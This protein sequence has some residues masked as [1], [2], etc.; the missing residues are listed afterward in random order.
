MPDLHAEAVT[1][2]RG[3]REVLRG[4]DLR[5]RAG[6]LTAILGPNGAGKST[7]LRCLGGLLPFEG[8]VRVGDALVAPM[9]PRTRARTLAFVPQ[10]SALRSALGVRE[11]VAQGRYAH[12]GGGAEIIARALRDAEAEE[13]V[14]RRFTSLSV[15]E[16][17]RVLLARALATQ[18]PVLLLDEPTAALDVR[19]AL[20]AFALLRR[21]AG[22]G[23]TLV[24]VV[25]DLAF[26]RRFADDAVLLA[27][28]EVVCAGEVHEVVAPGPVAEVYGV[29]MVE[30][31]EVRFEELPT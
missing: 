19:R 21:L 2:R 6:R 8:R 27:G 30:A 31:A 24:T 9:D 22:A 13:L 11:V 14:D 1:A 15:G 5:A 23:R 28:G 3:A 20:Q 10:R 17:Q 18:A 26:A 29:A 25:H 4:V 12:G 7:L 16:Q